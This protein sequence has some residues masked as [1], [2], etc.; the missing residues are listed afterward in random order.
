MGILASSWTRRGARHNLYPRLMQGSALLRHRDRCH[1]EG[2]CSPPLPV[3]GSLAKEPCC[4]SSRGPRPGALTHLYCSTSLP[5]S[6]AAALRNGSDNQQTQ[7][8]D[9][10]PE[11]AEPRPER[12]EGPAPLP[13]NA[14]T[15]P[16]SASPASPALPA[17]LLAGGQS[18]AVRLGLPAR[19]CPALPGSPRGREPSAAGP[20][21][22]AHGPGCCTEPAALRLRQRRAQLGGS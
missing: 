4:W 20:G 18:S 16:C 15:S 8:G 10:S 6:L 14:R 21:W 7:P 5:P 9:P 13:V 11:A 22:R 12:E 3:P 17:S 2:P 19:P 1:G